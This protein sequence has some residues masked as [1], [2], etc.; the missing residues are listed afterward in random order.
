MRVLIAAVV[1][2]ATGLSAC[3][4]S[5]SDDVDNLEAFETF[6]AKHRVGR[7]ADHWIEM[8]N[9]SGEWERVGLVFGYLDDYDECGKAIGGLK[10]VNYAREYRCVPANQPRAQ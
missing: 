10:K 2:V 6:V 7:D 1:T 5:R 9:M 3:N 4:S 8:K